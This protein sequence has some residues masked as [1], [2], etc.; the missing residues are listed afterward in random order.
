MTA[1][2]V[3]L[4]AARLPADPT[5]R[6]LIEFAAGGLAV[7]LLSLSMLAIFCSGVGYLFRRGSAKTTLLRKAAADDGAL[8]EE[9]VA[10]IAAAVA[11][12]VTMP[13]RIVHIRGL[14]ADELS[15]SR[16]GRIEHHASHRDT[17][18]PHH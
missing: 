5:L 16:G 14:T 1:A 9:T 13:H 8:P 6:Q 2:R 17:H 11:A 12:V 7:V 18:R 15:W 3:L 4:F 10:V